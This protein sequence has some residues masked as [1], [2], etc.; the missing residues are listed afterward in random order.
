M[1]TPQAQVQFDVETA[2][3]A[4]GGGNGAIEVV[5]I[6]TRGLQYLGEANNSFSSYKHNYSYNYWY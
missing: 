3:A 6:T 5:H 1:T 2:T 4:S